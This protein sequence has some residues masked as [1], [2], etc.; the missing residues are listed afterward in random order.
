MF[1][2]GFGGCLGDS[3]GHI[4]RIWTDIVDGFSYSCGFCLGGCV[5]DC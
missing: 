1:L 3:G 4:W 2:V 5:N